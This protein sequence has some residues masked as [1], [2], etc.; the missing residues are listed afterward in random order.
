M[1]KY[2]K[3][4][5]FLQNIF[6][7]LVAFIL[8]IDWF[9]PTG[10]LFRELGAQPVNVLILLIGLAIT[11]NAI[12]RGWK[13]QSYY[14][15]GELFLIGVVMLLLGGTFGYLISLFFWNY[16]VYEYK[17]PIFQWI[18][19]GGLVVC[20]PLSIVIL[21]NYFSN[22]RVLKIFIRCMRWALVMHLLFFIPDYLGVIADGNWFYSLFR[23]I[24]YYADSRPSGLFSEPSYF[25]LAICIYLPF[26]SF[27]IIKTQM[28]VRMF[29]LIVLVIALIFLML[30]NA[31][32]GY[33]VFLLQ[34]LVWLILLPS[35]IIFKLFIFPFCILGFLSFFYF[36]K[37]HFI[38]DNSL[39][40]SS[41]MRFGSTLLSINIALN[42]WLWSGIGFGQFNF[43]CIPSYA[44]DFLLES[45]E[46]WVIFNRINEYRAHTFNLLT[47]ILLE[48]G[49]TGLLGWMIL[50]KA[51]I[52]PKKSVK[53][54]LRQS[55]KVVVVSLVGVLGG[56]FSQDFYLY[57]PFYIMLVVFSQLRLLNKIELI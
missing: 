21:R 52:T 4:I 37:D 24:D 53:I 1:D 40:L 16:D 41:V 43:F 29:W 46:I 38:V 10:L 23:S 20:I 35:R 57:L 31:R 27:G 25:G 44:P 36:L 13:I 5:G 34:I 3:K 42:G 8:P 32:T 56:I 14:F 45:H 22:D 9:S 28:I 33:V 39:D 6:I 17:S 51:I 18:S 47:R 12:N 26:L 7:I 15:S 49:V 30:S 2:V 48:T 50:C 54:E 55:E 19:Q 11:P